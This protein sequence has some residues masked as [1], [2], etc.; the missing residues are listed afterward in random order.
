MSLTPHMRD[1]R[2]CRRLPGP[3]M[4]ASLASRTGTINCERPAA[5]GS[6]L[7]SLA[8]PGEGV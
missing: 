1:P 2:H 6:Q 4:I 7:A 5:A 3:S 8:L